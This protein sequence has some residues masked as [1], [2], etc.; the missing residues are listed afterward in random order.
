MS[1]SATTDELIENAA[2]IVNVIANRVSRPASHIGYENV[3][4]SNTDRCYMT[5]DVFKF[6]LLRRDEAPRAQIN[7]SQHPSV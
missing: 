7:I 5:V 1:S 6:L 2:Q 4:I 3:Q